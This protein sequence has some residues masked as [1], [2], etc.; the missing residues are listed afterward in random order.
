MPQI[1]AKEYEVACFVRHL[2]MA[3]IGG[4]WM[5]D[6]DVVPLALPACAPLSNGGAFTT[7]QGFVPS[8][9]S[10]SA[11]EYLRVTRLMAVTPWKENLDV[12]F[13]SFLSHALSVFFLFF[14]V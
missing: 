4:G 1:N 3:A 7:H 14:Y 10:A 8:L 13:S 9:V 12:S 2:A 6:Y 5:S 11:E